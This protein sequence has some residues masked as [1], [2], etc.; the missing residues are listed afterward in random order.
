MKNRKKF[1]LLSGFLVIILLFSISFA[2]EII[3]ASKSDLEKQIAELDKKISNSSSKLSALQKDTSK[4]KEYIQALTSEINTLENQIML[5][6]KKVD[7]INGDVL[8]TNKK[9]AAININIEK[10]EKEIE[11]VTIKIEEKKQEID[12]II[13]LLSKRMRAT[14]MAGSCSEIE[15]LLTCDDFSSFLTTSEMLKRVADHDHSIVSSLNKNI[16]QL[17]DMQNQLEKDK[18]D[19][20]IA[21]S[22]LDEEKESLVKKLDEQKA[23][24]KVFTDKQNSIT[25]KYT[26]ANNA[27]SK[28]N[29]DVSYYNDLVNGYESQTAQIEKQ[30]QDLIRNS[31]GGNSGGGSGG[32]DNNTTP[33]PQS[34][35]GFI[36]PLPYSSTYVS[37]YYGYRIHPIYGSQKFHSGI[38]LSCSG[39]GGSS[40]PFT[41]K[42]VASKA[43]TV[44]LSGWYYGYGNAVIIDHGGGFTTLY[45]HNY[46]NNVSTGQRVTQ[47]QQIAIMGTTGN[48]TGA[49]SHFEV[50][51]NGSTVNP[52]NYIKV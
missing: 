38:D 46:V 2:P 33:P 44:I 37:S 30:I 25:A 35:T 4:Q 13:N 29:K 26:A 17:V 34:S 9:I 40:G 39:G 3:A 48:S 7:L 41:K 36:S 27:L 45:G 18:L 5:I 32:P 12:E 24:Q 16:K 50:R 14:Y 19:L 11:E 20:E 23:E 47:G 10:K 42:I 6:S 28:M 49:H 22:D 21:K 15:I 52:L 51:I 43:G 31:T 8:A 1:K